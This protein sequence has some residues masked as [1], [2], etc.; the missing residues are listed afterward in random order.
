MDEEATIDDPDPFDLQRFVTAQAPV[1]DQAIAELR[2]GRKRSHWMW[3]VLPQ[4]VGLSSSRV[5][6][7]YAI[8]SLDEARAFLAQPTL[9]P[10]LERC[11]DAVLAHDPLDPSAILGW[12]D[13]LKLCSSMTLFEAVGAARAAEVLDRG[14]GGRRDPATSAVLAGWRGHSG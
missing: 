4:V 3:F 9:G 1:V 6:Q 11:V 14:Y 10:N 2:A 12:P 7:R 8:R 13:D 5:A